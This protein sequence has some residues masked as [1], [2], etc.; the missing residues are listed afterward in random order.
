[1]K[2]LILSITA[3]Y[4]HNICAEAIKEY[5]SHAHTEAEVKVLDALEYINPLLSKTIAQSYLH[6]TKYAKPLYGG[7]YRLAEK[8]KDPAPKIS[9]TRISHKLLSTMLKDYIAKFNPNFIIC[10]HVFAAQMMTEARKHLTCPTIGIVTDFAIHPYW[11]D[12]NLDY[13]VLP[14]ELLTYQFTQKGLA[15]DAILPFGL[16]IRKQ[17]SHYI[18]QTD[19]R[20]NIGIPNKPTVLVMGGSMGFGGMIKT[21]ERLNNLPLDFQIITVCGNNSRVNKKID[22]LS[23]DKVVKNYGY[24]DNINELM[25]ACDI[26]VSKPGGI[27]TSEALAKGIVMVMTKPIPGQEERNKEFLLNCG[28]AMSINNLIDVDECVYQ[29][30]TNPLKLD[31]MKQCVAVLSKPNSTRDLCEFLVSIN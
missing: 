15:A 9:P 26:L 16:P 25:S 24:V 12:T 4:G 18:S 19:A 27:T 31:A 3:G 22:K 29:L 23:F 28:A 14:N 13:Y 21:L 8:K 11:E 20:A 10:T 6:L 2:V 5:F 17:F 7:V 30:L 1:M